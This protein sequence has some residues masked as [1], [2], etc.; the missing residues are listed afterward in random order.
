MVTAI[1]IVLLV[2]I[3]FGIHNKLN[4]TSTQIENL[5][6]E[7]IRLRKMLESGVTEMKRPVEEETVKKESYR[8]ER[9]YDPYLK[10]LSVRETEEEEDKKTKEKVI[11]SESLLEMPSEKPLESPSESPVEV[12]IEKT[13]YTTPFIEQPIA[14]KEKKK[15]EPVNL[16]K[17]IGENLFGKIGILVLVIG[18]GFFVKY[19]IDKNYINEVVR[20][21]MGFA[22]GFLLLFIAWRLRKTYRTYSSLLAGGAFA[23]FYV[24]VAMAYHYYELFSQPVAFAILIVVTLLMSGLAI[25][26]DRRELAIIALGG[27][28]IAPFLVS[29]GAGDYMVLFTYVL[30]L[31]IGM[32]F[33]SFYK[34][35]GELPV[36]CFVLTWIVLF[37]YTLSVPS[38]LMPFQQ[39]LHLLIF[40]YSFY[41]LFLFSIISII[42]IKDRV[43]NLLLLI[44]L[45]LNNFVFMGIGLWLLFIMELGSNYG[46]FLTLFIGLVNL[47]LFF[48]VRNKD[49]NLRFLWQT[50]LATAVLFVSIAIP[51]QLKGTL[52]T[53]FWA[54]EMLILLWFYSRY[55]YRILEIFVMLLPLLTIISYIMDI[56]NAMSGSS[57]RMF[58]NGTFLTGIFTGIAFA[59]Y[60]WL[61]GKIGKKNNLAIWTSCVVLYMA[62]V[63]EMG[64]H[65]HS[66]RLLMS[67][68]TAFTMSVLFGLSVIFN[69]MKFPLVNYKKTYIGWISLS[70][71]LFAFTSW[72][73]EED[74]MSTLLYAI[75]WYSTVIF[76]LHILYVC[77]AYYAKENIRSKATGKMTVYLSILSTLFLLIITRNLLFHAELEDEISAGISVTLGL[78]GFLQMALGMRLHTK[79]L[80]MTSL[81]IFGI[82]ISKLLLHDLWLLPTVGKVIVFVLLGSILLILSF[83]YQKLKAVLF[84]DDN[85]DDLQASD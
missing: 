33:L 10:V 36:I 74:R 50:L 85:Q 61:S 4:N 57:I 22:V 7:I 34:R 9:N 83:L 82:V 53:L 75:R 52:I 2:V 6:Q 77:Y 59:I 71:I 64:I 84:E 67:Y 8:P 37:G 54:S 48:W 56:G 69:H 62:F 13:A 23:I 39:L 27:G 73:I 41:L 20:T 5:K 72:S 11:S 18:I 66:W 1:L 17:F 81:F 76:L 78:A 21:V 24:T 44:A 79:T 40:S 19:A 25:L 47:M 58:W 46:G 15:R 63:I 70:L 43:I 49:I 68:I 80:R 45:T 30:I 3:W 16:E 55:K 65:I 35:W 51:V 12:P 60:A 14:V 28:F 32:F 31:D 42:R 38:S 29:S 26:Y